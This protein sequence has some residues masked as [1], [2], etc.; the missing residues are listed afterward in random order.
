VQISLRSEHA[1]GRC[2]ILTEKRE[3]SIYADGGTRPAASA[4]SL[5]GNT[6]ATVRLHTSGGKKRNTVAGAQAAAVVDI[7]C[8]GA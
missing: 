5:H 1:L 6:Q 7:R 8:P 2:A 4:R 3:A